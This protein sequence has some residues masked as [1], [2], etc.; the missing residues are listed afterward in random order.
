MKNLLLFL[1]LT[2]AFSVTISIPAAVKAEYKAR[3]SY[4]IYQNRRTKAR[5]QAYPPLEC[6][7]FSNDMVY[8]DPAEE[9]II[10]NCLSYVY[11]HIKSNPDFTISKDY[12]KD[13]DLFVQNQSIYFR[14]TFKDPLDF[15][16]N[17]AHPQLR[18]QN[19]R[20]G[21]D[22]EQVEEVSAEK[23]NFCF[24]TPKEEMILP[25]EGGFGSPIIRIQRP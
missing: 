8:N 3:G 4:E 22:Q 24:L 18:F 10:D 12:K 2:T 16:K 1:I 21:N 15:C 23:P 6:Y 14:V 11:Y 7:D 17:L 13:H 20:R 25:Y 9:T 5:P 19:I